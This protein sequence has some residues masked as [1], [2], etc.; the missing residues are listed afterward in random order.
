MKVKIDEKVHIKHDVEVD[1]RD[2][3]HEFSARV[4]EGGWTVASILECVDAVAMVLGEV[5]REVIEQVKDRQ[6]RKIA[7]ALL[8]ESRRWDVD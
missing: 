5:P 4:G 8:R 1:I 3:I 6:R 7:A 2:L